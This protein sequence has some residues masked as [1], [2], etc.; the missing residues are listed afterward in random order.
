MGA[1]KLTGG[2]GGKLVSCPGPRENMGPELGHHRL[3]LFVCIGWGPFQMSLS[4][5]RTKLSALGP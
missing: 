4:R 5:A 3:V 2:E 1:G